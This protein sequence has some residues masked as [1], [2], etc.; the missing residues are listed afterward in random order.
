MANP[1]VRFEEKGKVGLKDEMGKILIPAA[2]E[3]L[4]WSDGNFSVIGQVTGYK[5]KNHWGIIHL[6]K[7]LIT[8]AD[9]ES[10]TYPGGERIIVSKKINPFTLKFGCIDLAGK[11]T[12]PFQ[13]D[14]ITVSGLRA[15]VFVKN[16][17]DFEYG[18]IDLNDKGLIPMRYRHVHPIGTLRYGVENTNRKTALFSEE[19]IQLTDFVI[20]S[21]SSFR[22]GLAVIYQNFAQ[23]LVNRE[24][25]IK[26]KSVYR[27]LRI[28]DDGVVFARDFDDWKILDAENQVHHKIKADQLSGSG[29]DLYQITLAGK[30][31]LLDK[32]LKMVLPLLYDFVGKEDHGNRVVGI[33]R[34]YGVIR[35]NTSLILPLEFDSVVLDNNFVRASRLLQGRSSWSLYDT[36]GIQKT[37]APFDFIGPWNGNFFPVKKRGYWGAMNRYGEE[38]IHCVFDSLRSWKEDLFAVQLR[39]HFGIVDKEE[40]WLLPPQRYPVGLMNEDY[41]FERRDSTTFLKNF[42]GEIIYF[43]THPISADGDCLKE[44]LSNGTVKYVSFQGFEISRSE[45]PITSLDVQAVFPSSEGFRAIKKDGKYGFVDARGRLRIANRYDDIGDFHEGLAPVKLIGKWGYVNIQDQIAINPNYESVGPF[46]NA[47]AIVWRNGKAGLI[48]PEGKTAL[49]FRYD[50]IQRLPDQTFLMKVSNLYGL[51]DRKGNVLIEPRFDV[52]RNLG[53]GFVIAGRA[54]KFGLLTLQGFSMVPMIYDGLVQGGRDEYIGV[55]RSWW[56]ALKVE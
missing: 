6:Q 44:V 22:H 42:H 10:L 56:K 36:F 55:T 41:F 28:N 9:F 46:A 26:I 8:P 45:A 3:A 23:G 17:P 1:F 48:D 21:I 33:G 30:T 12:I 19:G 27:E 25:E 34:R 29:K 50:S 49:A 4:G 35:M 5:L 47:T 32:N 52:L 38:F 37:V 43:T 20:D 31:G 18:L 11:L 24:G 54:G 15:I 53:N 51:A 39:G 14:G 7:Q 2:F 40:K 16:G 13:Y